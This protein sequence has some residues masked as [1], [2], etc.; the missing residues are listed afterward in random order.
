VEEESGRKRE[1]GRLLSGPEVWDVL[2]DKGGTPI[3]IEASS[4]V[5]VDL[6]QVHA[7][8]LRSGIFAV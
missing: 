3:I 2:V 4:N 7:G 1:V 5:G 8:V 6:F